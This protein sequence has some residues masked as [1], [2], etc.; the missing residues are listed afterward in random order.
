MNMC[1]KSN[2]VKEPAKIF[3]QR[4]DSMT[5]KT[6]CTLEREDCNQKTKW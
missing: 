3:I 6:L 1:N 4:N 2:Q 5:K